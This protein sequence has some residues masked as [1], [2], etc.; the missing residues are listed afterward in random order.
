MFA[1]LFNKRTKRHQIAAATPQHFAYNSIPDFAEQMSEISSKAVALL[2][3]YCDSEFEGMMSS[4]F[5][6]AGTHEGVG[7]LIVASKFDLFSDPQADDD[8]KNELLNEA[9]VLIENLLG[10]VSTFFQI[11]FY[12]CYYTYSL[13]FRV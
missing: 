3:P 2:S 12:F 6:D 9:K 5:Q 7:V 8:E 4:K 1:S 11:V 10:F 13:G